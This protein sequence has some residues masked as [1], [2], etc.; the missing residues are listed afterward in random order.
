MMENSLVAEKWNV[1]EFRIILKV[2]LEFN[3]IQRIFMLLNVCN[4]RQVY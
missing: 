4:F 3:D 1:L 2:S